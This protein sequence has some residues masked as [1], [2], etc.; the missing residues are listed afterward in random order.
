MDCHR[1]FQIPGFAITE[2]LR[3]PPDGLEITAKSLSTQS[4]CPYCQTLSTKKHSQYIRRPKALPWGEFSVRLSLIVNRYFC[5]NANC[6]RATFAE[7]IPQIASFHAQRTV[8][9]TKVLRAIAFETSAEATARISRHLRIA[10]SPDTVLRILRATCFSNAPC[11]RVLGVDDWALKRGQHYGTILVDL[12]T[13]KPVDLIQ[14]RSAETLQGWLEGHPHVEIISRDR[15]KEYKAGIDAALPD[16]VQIVDRWHLYLNLRERVE[17]ILVKRSATPK[18]K[19]PENS[20]RQKRFEYVRYLHARGYSSRVIARALD[21][22]RGTVISYIKAEQLPD[23]KK[24]TPRKSKLEKYDPYLRKRWRE[25]CRNSNVLWKELRQLGYSGKHNSVHRYLRRYRENKSRLPRQTA[26]LFIIA[27]EKLE[28]EDRAYLDDLLNR[29]DHL[30]TIYELT[31][32]F[33]G[34]LSEQDDTKFDR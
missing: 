25:G 7:R 34:M 32:E 6:I 23:W 5:E 14:G 16:V 2:L 29:Y 27:P 12:E 30:K 10:V 28:L 26:W 8:Q 9:L 17:K 13:R 15:S 19:P 3:A 4:E 33:L 20:K 18:K 24:G 22:S 11:P 21:I 31:Q 1:Y